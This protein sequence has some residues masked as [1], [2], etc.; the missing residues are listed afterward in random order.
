MCG[1]SVSCLFAIATHLVEGESGF[2]QRQAVSGFDRRS[3]T[4]LASLTPHGS[5]GHPTIVSAVGKTS[6]SHR[7]RAPS[8]VVKPHQATGEMAALMSPAMTFL[9]K[10]SDTTYSPLRVT[11]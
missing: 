7:S 11:A 6:A 10:M 9:P 2:R 1:L 4:E 8:P 3:E 5:N